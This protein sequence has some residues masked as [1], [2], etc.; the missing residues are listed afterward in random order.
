[1]I[2]RDHEVPASAV[3]VHICCGPCAIMP[4]VRLRGEGR[5]VAGLF[6]NPNIHPLTE[7]LRRRGAALEAARR[8]GLPLV[9]PPART[10]DLGAWLA[11]A[12]NSALVGDPLSPD[13]CAWCYASRLD[14]TAALAARHGCAAFTTSLL[15]SPYQ[16]HDL[17]VAAANA[18]SARH[19]VPFL[20]RDFR[21][22]WREG[23]A[24]AR[25]WDLYRQKYCACIYS[26]AER[27]A[28]EL[29]NALRPEEFR[30]MPQRR[31]KARP[32]EP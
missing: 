22:D 17:I 18:A 28:P 16:K 14:A 1:M 5:S 25:E 3:L 9:P 12:H 26:E 23:V 4:V 24:R 13:R 2:G 31:A 19:H 11:D 8:L 32:I 27:F 10:W 6:H 15:Y 29:E 30:E 7:Y 21:P 20:Y